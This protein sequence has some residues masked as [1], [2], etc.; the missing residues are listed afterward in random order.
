[1]LYDNYQ[2]PWEDDELRILRDAAGKF[3]EKEFAPKTDEWIA[4][5]KIDRDAWLQAGAGGLLCAAIP[6]AYGGGGGDYRHETVIMEEHLKRGTMMV[7]AIWMN[8]RSPV[9]TRM[10][11]CRRSTAGPTTS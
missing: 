6:E 8:M 3:F 5:G 9:C 2:P 11:G 1:M 10:R 4:Q 7:P